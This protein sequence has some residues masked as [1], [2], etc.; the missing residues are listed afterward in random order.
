MPKALRVKVVVCLT[1]G[2][3]DRERNFLVGVLVFSHAE[4]PNTQV[5]N[6]TLIVFESIVVGSG[7]DIETQIHAHF[8]VRFSFD[9]FPF[10]SAHSVFDNSLAKVPW[11]NVAKVETHLVAAGLGWEILGAVWRHVDNGDELLVAG[12]GR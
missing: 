1:S 8:K 3:D 12:N 6:G 5:H 9:V 2:D 7:F 4:L 11:R 10:A